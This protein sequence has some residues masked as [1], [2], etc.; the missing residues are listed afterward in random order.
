MDPPK[1]IKVAFYK[2]RGDWRNKVIRW[3]TK[4]KYTHAEL[5]L[6]D[7]STWLSIS[8]ILSSRVASREKLEYDPNC[9][10]FLEFEISDEQLQI[11]LNF[12][13]DTEGNRYDWI[14]MI[15]SQFLPFSGLVSPLPLG[16]DRIG[17][18]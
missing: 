6:P 10:D 14:G 12:F 8:P 11:I 4:S 18:L 13:E 9:W 17:Y 16:P 5:V 15:L 1:R 2:S 3:W 7:E